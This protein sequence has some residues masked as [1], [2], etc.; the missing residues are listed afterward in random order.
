MKVI[1]ISTELLTASQ[2]SFEPQPRLQ[3]ANSMADGEDFNQSVL[4]ASLQTGTHVLLPSFVMDNEEALNTSSPLLGKCVGP[5]TVVT[6]PF[7]VTGEVVENLFPRNARRIILRTEDGSPVAFFAG[8]A[9]DMAELGYDLIGFE[10]LP[11]LPNDSVNVYYDL[12]SKGALV[13]EGLDLSKVERD[14]DFFLFA[15]PVK[16]AGVE[17]APCR[18]LLVADEMNWNARDSRLFG[19]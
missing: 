6:V 19:R 15:Q 4:Y 2:K 11:E 8:A 16:I 12:M 17:A 18:A 14:G 9:K 3:V 1:D 10:G 13:L 7:P 5:V